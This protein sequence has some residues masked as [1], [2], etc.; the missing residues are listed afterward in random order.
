M[1]QAGLLVNEIL[2]KQLAKHGFT[3][4]KHTP[5]LWK[6]S[7]KPIQFTLVVD[8]FWV[9]YDENH[10]AQDIIKVLREHYKSVLV[11]WKGEL[12]CSMKLD[13]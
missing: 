13:L 8:D 6:N 5:G 10:D 11:D 3:Q 4:T 7:S 9:K 1:A 2:A 12:F